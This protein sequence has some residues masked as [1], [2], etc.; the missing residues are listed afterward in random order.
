MIDFTDHNA[1]ITLFNEAQRVETDNRNRAAE[2]HSFIDDRAG[3]WE[4]DVVASADK[5]PRYTF[6]LTGP[7]VNQIAGEMEQAD[8]DIRVVNLAQARL[9]FGG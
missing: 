8:F 1:V 7:I 6:D 3:Q 5:K 9:D 2:A 4:T